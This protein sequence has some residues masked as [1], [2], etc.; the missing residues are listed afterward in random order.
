MPVLKELWR[1]N[2]QT[3]SQLY[4]HKMLNDKYTMLEL[5]RLIGILI[6]NKLVKRKLIENGETQYFYAIG[7]DQYFQII[8]QEKEKAVKPKSEA[9]L[10][11]NQLK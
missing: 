1:K 8:E 11:P 7:K 5:K 9:E 2:P 3:L 4:Q 10:T 6:D